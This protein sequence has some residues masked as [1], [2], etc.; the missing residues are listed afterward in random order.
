MPNILEAIYRIVNNPIIEVRTYYTGRNRANSVGEALE[1][2]VKDVFA[3]T[4]NVAEEAERN[5]TFSQIFSYLGNQNNPPDIMLRGGDAIE[6]KKVQSPTSALALNSSY[7]KSKLYAD[8]PM[9]TAACSNCEQWSEKDIAYVVGHTSDTSLKYL[10]FV[11]G[12]CF[13]ASREVYER[14]KQTIS[15]GVN[16]IPGVDFAE[17]NELGKV[18]KV[19]PL[20]I[21]DLRIR[22]MWHI[23]NPHKVFNYLNCIDDASRFQLI[24]LMRAEKFNSFPV[25]DKN[26]LLTL[27]KD[28]YKIADV[29][30]KNPDNPAQLLKGKLITFRVY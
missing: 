15:D 6:T 14:I 1:N 7:P 13:A 17:T 25:A 9:I 19:D 21:T 10:W 12:D 2:Y 3:D 16:N 11:Y 30:I 18:K 22:G 24:V 28:N 4:F 20:G 23:E 29:D 26:R 27:T 5:R 8:S